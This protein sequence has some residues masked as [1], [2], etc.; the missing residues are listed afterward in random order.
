MN[1]TK[2]KISDL[3][4]HHERVVA[5]ALGGGPMTELA[6]R[7]AQQILNL[8]VQRGI[9]KE[10]REFIERNIQEVA[11]IIDSAGARELTAQVTELQ[12][13]KDSAIR[14]M[15]PYQEIGAELQLPWGASVHDKILPTIQG[16]KTQ[17]RELTEALDQAKLTFFFVRNLSHDAWRDPPN[18]EA[19]CKRI[20][21]YAKM[22]Y[23]L[24]EAVL[25][26]IKG[27]Q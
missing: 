8:K 4:S 12:S 27:G 23:D 15:P 14:A 19:I 24:I 5:C 7:A 17:V 18:L 11:E 25:A 21:D 13:W 16:L 1:L 9:S 20:E 22:E 2:D 3:R 26:R 6:K 10:R